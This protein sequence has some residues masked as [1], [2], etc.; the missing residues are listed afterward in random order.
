MNYFNLINRVMHG[1][2]Y[3]NVPFTL[4]P[5]F[6]GW[7]V[8]FPWCSGDVAIH[9]HTYGSAN[10]KVET[11]QFPWDDGDVSVLSPL[12]AVMRIHWYYDELTAQK[13]Q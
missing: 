9:D 7:Q 2:A 11:Y 10:G 8:R 13:A 5:L 6:E 1:L 12:Q 3:F 4:N